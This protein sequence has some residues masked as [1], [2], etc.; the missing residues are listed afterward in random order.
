VTGATSE[1]DATG[2]ASERANF[3]AQMW[4]LSA[5]GQWRNWQTHG[6]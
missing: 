2:P 1:T 3:E 5:S 6:T 4:Y